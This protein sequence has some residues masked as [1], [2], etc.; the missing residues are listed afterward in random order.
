MAN[1]CKLTEYKVQHSNGEDFEQIKLRIE[2]IHDMSTRQ[3]ET[4]ETLAQTVGIKMDKLIDVIAGKGMIP[5]D[6]FKW[7]VVF[8]MLFVFCI[9]F[10]V[11]AAKDLVGFVK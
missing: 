3:A 7:L 5:V 8:V 1:D 2:E 9:V 10:G 11:S 4:L 6:V